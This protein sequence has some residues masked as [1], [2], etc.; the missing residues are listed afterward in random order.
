MNLHGFLDRRAVDFGGRSWRNPDQ[1]GCG[2]RLVPAIASG[3]SDNGSSAGTG[4]GNAGAA[5][6]GGFDRQIGAD[7]NGSGA[8]GGSMAAGA[9]VVSAVT[10]VTC[11]CWSTTRG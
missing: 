2:R 3:S 1:A 8:A 5:P 7:S 11:R 10:S 4:Y 6:V 9:A